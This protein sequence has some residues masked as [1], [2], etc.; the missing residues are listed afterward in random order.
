MVQE[1]GTQAGTTLL[2]CHGLLFCLS[3]LFVSACSTS[4]NAN[5]SKNRARHASCLRFLSTLGWSVAVDGSVLGD[6]G[7]ALVVGDG[8]RGGIGGVSGSL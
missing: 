4:I 1:R 7:S 5:R 8:V 3:L 6:S 2:Q